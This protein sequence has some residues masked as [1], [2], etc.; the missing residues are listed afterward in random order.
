MVYVGV[1]DDPAWIKQD[2][3]VRLAQD[4]LAKRGYPSA[5]CVS[6]DISGKDCQ[7]VFQTT[8]PALRA[9]VHVDRK[10]RRVKIVE[11]I[12]MNQPQKSL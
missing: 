9:V 11:W 12:H 7:F 6:A 5:N 2:D 4:F 1:G 3:S 10:S 8:D